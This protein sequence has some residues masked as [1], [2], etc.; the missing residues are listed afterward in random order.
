MKLL[1]G[2]STIHLM[3]PAFLAVLLN[4]L[5]GHSTGEKVADELQPPPIIFSTMLWG[6]EG[7]AIFAF[8]PWDNH[9]DENST[10]LDVSTTSG[11][12]SKKYAYYGKGPLRLLA[13]KDNQDEEID[14]EN[15]AEDTAAVIL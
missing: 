8:A 13:T 7:S 15:Q 10:I 4:G 9:E 5:Q 12:I 3:L 2:L 14:S 11:I 6:E 1:R